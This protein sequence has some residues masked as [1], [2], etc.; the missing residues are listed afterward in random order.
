MYRSDRGSHDDE[1]KLRHHP[2]RECRDMEPRLFLTP[3]F[4]DHAKTV[5]ERCAVK[6]LCLHVGM[7]TSFIPPGI[8][9]GM[10]EKERYNL[11]RRN[12]A[13]RLLDEREKGQSA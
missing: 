6:D 1:K 5:C 8:W 13:R 12:R 10:S 11:R 7:L 4:E 9:G 2:L 3:A